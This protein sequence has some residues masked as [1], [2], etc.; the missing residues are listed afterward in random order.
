ML[1]HGTSIQ[2]RMQAKKVHHV[3]RIG[4]SAGGGTRTRLGH[5]LFTGTVK[6]SAPSGQGKSSR[7]GE[8]NQIYRSLLRVHHPSP[9]LLLLS[10]LHFSPSLSC[11]SSM[12][13]PPKADGRLPNWACSSA[14][15]IVTSRGFA[16]YHELRKMRQL[17]MASRSAW[18][19]KHNHING[20]ECSGCDWR[21]RS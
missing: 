7:S 8:C 16:R 5:S 4:D 10:Q 2:R 1:S 12:P 14:H 3:V 18:P 13:C 20:F 19:L 9:S 17:T 11:I 6:Y 21:D 15:V